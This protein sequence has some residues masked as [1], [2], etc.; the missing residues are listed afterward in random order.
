MEFY[1]GPFYKYYTYFWENKNVN[2]KR[3]LFYFDFETTGLNPYHSKIIE[4]SFILE[5]NCDYD[6]SQPEKFEDNYYITNLVDPQTKYEKKITDITGIYPDD[7]EDKLPI[8]EHIN[9]INEFIMDDTYES[10][11]SYLV[12]HNCDAFDK[13]FLLNNF[14]NTENKKYKSWKYIDTL[15]LAK[16]LLP[17]QK[18]YSLKNLCNHF[19]IQPG[20]HRALSDTIALRNLYHHLMEI[21]SQEVN[22]SVEYLLDNSHIVYDYIY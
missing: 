8:Q 21:L 11:E 1:L 6:I 19:N 22:L 2:V 7:L 3:E 12:A 14:K 9:I 18:S 20:N 4:Y 5:E 16:K 13:L 10:T 15:H 17:D